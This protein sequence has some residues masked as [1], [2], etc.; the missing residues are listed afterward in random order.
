M[1]GLN[2]ISAQCAAI[3]FRE[4]GGLTL[5][6]TLLRP[7]ILRPKTVINPDENGMVELIV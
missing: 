7:A 2:P 6:D 4:P 3:C 1:T 5:G